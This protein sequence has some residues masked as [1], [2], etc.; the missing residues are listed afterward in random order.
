MEHADNIFKY[1]QRHGIIVRNRSNVKGCEGCLRI[2]VGTAKENQLLIDAL[3]A[4][5]REAVN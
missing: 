1:L 2:T 4:F 5:D 3:K